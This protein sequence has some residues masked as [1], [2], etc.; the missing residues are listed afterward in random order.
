MKTRRQQQEDPFGVAVGAD[1]DQHPDGDGGDGHRDVA[2]HAE[3]LEGGA[4]AG[5]LGDHQPDVGHGEG[6]HGEG[7]QAQGELLTDQGGQP[8]AGVGGQAG[9][10]LLDADVAHGDQ[11]HEEQRPVAELG[12]GRRVGG[13]APGVVA[14]VGGDEPGP[15]GGQ[16]D[17]EAAEPPVGHQTVNGPTDRPRTVTGAP[18]VTAAA[19]GSGSGPVRASGR[20]SRRRPGSGPPGGRR[21]PPPPPTCGGHRSAARPPRA[22]WA[23][24]PTVTGSA[25][26]TRSPSTVSAGLINSWSRGRSQTIRPSSSTRATAS[27]SSGQ[28]S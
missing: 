1:D 3:Q 8:L 5:E 21:R 14:G 26:P 13:H 6:Q 9:D 2:R 11:H 19:S 4:D 27:S 12:P 17:E 15:G 23:W 24:M 20:R 7:R 22:T 25:S 16:V 10:H 18:V 28:S